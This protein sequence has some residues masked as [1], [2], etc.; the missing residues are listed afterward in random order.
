MSTMEP[1]PLLRRA[2]LADAGTCAAT[3]MLLVIAAAPLSGLLGLPVGLLQGAGL[4]LLPFA[5]L[6]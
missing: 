5:V 2:L 1:S 4:F 6:V 3:G